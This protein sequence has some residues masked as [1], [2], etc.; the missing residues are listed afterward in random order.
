MS[1]DGARVVLVEARAGARA[2]ELPVFLDADCAGCLAL[3]RPRTEGVATC[4]VGLALALLERVHGG[5]AAV[6]IGLYRDLWRRKIG[7]QHCWW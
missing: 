6:D 5:D 4:P 1:T 3:P 7:G 2:L